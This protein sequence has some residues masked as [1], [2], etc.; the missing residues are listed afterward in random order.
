MCALH[1]VLYNP[2]S[3]LII[4]PLYKMFFTLI[5]LV[6]CLLFKL[7]F[8]QRYIGHIQFGTIL[9]NYSRCLLIDVSFNH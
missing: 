5:I 2:P 4:Y 3:P 7:L 1:L 9:F 8:K 6:V